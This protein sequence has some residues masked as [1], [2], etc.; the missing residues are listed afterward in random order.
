MKINSINNNYQQNNTNF[1]AGKIIIKNPEM[2]PREFLSKIANEGSYQRFASLL[3]ERNT[4]LLIKFKKGFLGLFPK[5]KLYEFNEKNNTEKY[6]TSVEKL[7]GVK[8]LEPF[9]DLFTASEYG[10]LDKTSKEESLRLI[11]KYN[12]S[13]EKNK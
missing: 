13:I 4:D 7:F 8:C 10:L 6:I 9:S 5:I 1:K 12:N 3:T 2:M 11:E